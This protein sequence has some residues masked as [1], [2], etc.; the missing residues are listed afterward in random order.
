MRWEGVNGEEKSVSEKD[1]VCEDEEAV[2]ED[3]VE[4]NEPPRV[5]G[6]STD[7]PGSGVWMV[8]LRFR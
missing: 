7:E 4:E 6:E 5:R 2:D 1:R 3:A 8:R